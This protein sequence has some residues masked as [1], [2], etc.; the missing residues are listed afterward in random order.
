M[1]GNTNIVSVLLLRLILLAAPLLVHK[2]ILVGNGLSGNPC[3]L[4]GFYLSSE[5]ALCQAIVMSFSNIC[6]AWL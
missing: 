6:I 3:I 1:I 2:G 4:K 5:K